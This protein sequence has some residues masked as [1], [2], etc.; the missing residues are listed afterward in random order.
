VI[1]GPFDQISLVLEKLESDLNSGNEWMNENRLK[2]N[3]SKTVFMIVAS[4][5]QLSQLHH[6]RLR[7]NTVEIKRVRELKF[8]GVISDEG[9][10]WST[11]TK[12]VVSTCNYA[13]YSLKPFSF[14]ISS[15]NKSILANALVL[16]HIKY[17][18]VVWMKSSS[19]NYKAVDNVIRRS[20]RFVFGLMKFNSVS[21][22]ICSK[23]SI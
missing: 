15:I 13:L 4:P 23:V 2:L 5:H 14:V 20:A 3:I 16:S 21:N 18:S 19:S 10:L 6:V 11:H 7:I 22:I 12:K 9:L 17:A 8:L 1:S